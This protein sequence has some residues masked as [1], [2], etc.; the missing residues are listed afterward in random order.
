MKRRELWLVAFSAVLL[1]LA[2][3]TADLGAQVPA[4][5]INLRT[6]PKGATPAGTLTSTASGANTQALDVA[7]IRAATL[8]G[9]GDLTVTG[10]ATLL[11]AA[12]TT[13]LELSCTVG[14]VNIRVAGSNVTATRGQQVAATASFKTRTTAAVYAASEGA[15]VTVSCTEEL[16]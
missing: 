2:V 8:T 14:A 16:Q 3:G 6:L 1:A 12:D 4:G 15:G 13:R 9:I 10:S 11:R 7:P 5:T